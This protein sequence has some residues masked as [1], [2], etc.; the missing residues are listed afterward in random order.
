MHSSGSFNTFWTR[1]GRIIVASL[2]WKERLQQQQSFVSDHWFSLSKSDG[3]EQSRHP[4]ESKCEQ[5]A[6]IWW[7]LEALIITA[8][9]VSLLFRLRLSPLCLPRSSVFSFVFASSLL[10]LYFTATTTRRRLPK[11]EYFTSEL[12]AE[13][14]SGKLIKRMNQI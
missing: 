1:R 14:P 10:T 4:N 8:V 12:R 11:P 3:S 7:S 5:F 2:K 6:Q 13:M 9:C